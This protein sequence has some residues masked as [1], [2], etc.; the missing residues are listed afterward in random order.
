MAH[1]SSGMVAFVTSLSPEPEK[2]VE[3]KEEK[4]F[5]SLEEALTGEVKDED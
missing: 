1:Q 3:T 4:E 5:Q 2:K